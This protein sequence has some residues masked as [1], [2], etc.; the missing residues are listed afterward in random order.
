V[1][2]RQPDALLPQPYAKKARI[3]LSQNRVERHYNMT[4]VVEMEKQWI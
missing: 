2:S 3:P 4:V 1:L